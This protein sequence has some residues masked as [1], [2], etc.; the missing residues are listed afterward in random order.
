MNTSELINREHEVIYQT[1][2]RLAV[3]VERAEG[4]RVYDAEGRVYLD[5]LAGIA[6]NALGHSHPRIIEAIEKQ[7]R[8][9][10]HISNFFYQEPQ[11]R[12]AEMLTAKTGYDKVVFSNSGAEAWET[13][14]KLARAYGSTH[15]K[16]GNI[17]GFS[18][19]FH[20]RTYGALS[21]M[22]KPLYKQGM[23]PFLPGTAILQFNN[24]DLLRNSVDETTCA[25][26]LEF[27]QGEGGV[28]EASPEFVRTLQ[29][30]K[31]KF[32][33][34]IIADE[35]QAGSGRTGDFFAFEKYDIQPDIVTMAKGIGG[36]L[37]LG[38]VL[39][40]EELS[41][42]WQQGQHGTTYGGNALACATGI[43]VMEELE[44]GVMQNVRESGT[45]LRGQLCSLRDEY[46]NYI[47]EVRGRGLFL[48]LVLKE[49]ATILRDELLRNF[50][51]TNA[52]A[53]NVL[54]I[55]PPLVISVSE[56]DE[57]VTKLRRSINS[58]V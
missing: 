22:D 17:V 47:L 42:V 41:R 14:M 55:I 3:A 21:V 54:R 51:I 57:F 43:V 39:A 8:K 26:G 48:G 37:P 45:Y 29:E 30:L 27:I 56:I 58:L 40:N 23:E 5:M 2:K 11:V 52:T 24:S 25:V 13:A 16:T 33:F 34:V 18:G 15:G 38:A 31:E 32:G 50:V 12:L 35:V 4:C 9:Y 49:D 44:N 20:G 28:T 1:Y 19:G 10:L 7:A 53:T 36:G 6:V 46:P